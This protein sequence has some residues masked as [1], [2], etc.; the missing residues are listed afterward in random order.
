M[1][2]KPNR[3]VERLK[4]RLVAR[5]DRQVDGKYYKHTFSLVAKFTSVRSLVALAF[6]QNWR[7]HHLDIN[8]AYLHGYLDQEVY[9]KP[10]AGHKEEQSGKVCRLKGSLYGLNQT[11][12]QW[13][14]ELTK[15]LLQ[16]NFQ[17]SKRDYSLFTKHTS[18]R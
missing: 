15:F 2:H 18:G 8:N 13:N 11:S 9:M 10:P 1:K 3:E 17:H 16:E 12:R 14:I 7:L 5:G 4:A 6:S